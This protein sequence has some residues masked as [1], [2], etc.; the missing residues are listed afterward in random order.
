MFFQTG[1]VNYNKNY[2]ENY[3]TFKILPFI[4][5]EAGWK[6]T[7]IGNIDFSKK[8]SIQNI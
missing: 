8:N 6:I 2:F 5:K 4:L 3:E 7:K 1:N